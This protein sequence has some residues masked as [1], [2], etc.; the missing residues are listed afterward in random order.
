[1]IDNAIQYT[2]FNDIKVSVGP[3]PEKNILMLDSVTKNEL[4]IA[5]IERMYQNYYAYAKD[6]FFDIYNEKEMYLASP[7]SFPFENRIINLYELSKKESLS[8]DIRIKIE[9]TM[10]WKVYQTSSIDYRFV[11][12]D[13]KEREII[14]Y[15]QFIQYLERKYCPIVWHDMFYIFVDNQYYYDRFSKIKKDITRILKDNGYS[16]H[17]KIKSIIDD[18]IYRVKSEWQKY[19]EKTI[20]NNSKNL[21]PV[22]NG[23]ICIDNG[24]FKLL[25]VSPVWGYTYSLPVFFDDT[26]NS[27]VIS[28]FI[29][30]ICAE[31]GI[32][33]EEKENILIQIPA[34]ALMQES[35]LP[36]YLLSGSGANGKSTY[37]NLLKDFVGTENCAAI[38]LQSISSD[39]FKVAELYGKLF[40]IYADL[41]K[42]IVNDTGI[43]K[44]ITG[45][46]NICAEKKFCQPFYFTNKS[47][48]VFSSNELPTVMENTYAFWRRWNLVE[49]TNRF[50]M[51]VNFLAALATDENKSAFLNLI[52][53]KIIN[54]KQNGLILTNKSEEI[55]EMW[56]MKSSSVYA[57]IKDCISEAPQNQT[58][59]RR[60]LLNRYLN[61]CTENGLSEEKTSILYGDIGILFPFSKDDKWITTNQQRERYITGIKAKLTISQ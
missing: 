42:T 32:R 52:L 50:E 13:E 1:M 22:K 43:F 23:V 46:D 34:Q 61:Y 48:L 41:P 37:L 53:E 38:S 15:N 59:S 5:F 8:R 14:N 49:F 47:V 29:Q 19:G 58:I 44:M 24:E 40:N 26:A 36:A 28:K 16:D 55:M 9:L 60:E 7:E 25:P 6:A 2:T 11:E 18:I 17:S 45:D 3:E 56:K 21:I 51:D 10:L 30:D 57:F 27:T 54:I 33:N 12:R 4:D 35:S 39:K 20:F 31:N